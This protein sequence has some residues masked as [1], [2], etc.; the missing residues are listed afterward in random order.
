MP[1][2]PPR[3]PPLQHYNNILPLLPLLLRENIIIGMITRCF[4]S[5]K[6][7]GSVKDTSGIDHLQ[8]NLVEKAL[9]F[10]GDVT[11]NIN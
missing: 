10:E 3:S 4:L 6:H 5:R 8:L 1:N 7:E 2:Y 9:L 11:S